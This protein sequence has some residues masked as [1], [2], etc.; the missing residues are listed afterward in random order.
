MGVFVLFMKSN[1]TIA[2]EKILQYGNAYL[3]SA[4]STPE[5]RIGAYILLEGALHDARRYKGYGL[6]EVDGQRFDAATKK[7]IITDETRR[8]YY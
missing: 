2:I 7:W 4:H 5:R 8:F 6:L 3:A 1:K